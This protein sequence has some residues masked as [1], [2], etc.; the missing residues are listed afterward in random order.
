[1]DIKMKKKFTMS[2]WD[3]Q[4]QIGIHVHNLSEEWAEW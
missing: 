1:M 3:L 4:P 2:T